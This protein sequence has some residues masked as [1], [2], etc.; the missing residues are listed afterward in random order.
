MTTKTLT[1]NNQILDALDEAFDE[2][3]IVDDGFLCGKQSMIDA[4]STKLD[5]LL[6]PKQEINTIPLT[7]NKSIDSIWAETPVGNYYIVIDTGGIMKVYYS[8]VG[9]LGPCESF[10]EGKRIAEADFKERIIN[11]IAS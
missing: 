11:C 6:N 4:F 9:I 10:D 7:W 3:F 5:E 2:L 1:I 8:E